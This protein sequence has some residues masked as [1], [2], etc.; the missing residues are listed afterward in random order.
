MNRTEEDEPSV[1]FSAFRFYLRSGGEED[2][3]EADIS[4]FANKCF[5]YEEK[6]PE[7]TQE[8]TSDAMRPYQ[9]IVID[10]HTVLYLNHFEVRYTDGIKDGEEYLDWSTVNIS[11]ML[12]S[13]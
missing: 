7:A 2:L 13:N 4:D 11:G 3:I 1:D 10:D 5:A 8:E 9:E 12:L 6:H